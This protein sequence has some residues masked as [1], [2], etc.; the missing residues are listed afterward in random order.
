[1]TSSVVELQGISKKY[2]RRDALRDVTLSLE[3]G[4][5]ALLGRNGAGKTTM[6]RILAGDTAADSGEVVRAGTRIDGGSAQRRR[7]HLAQTGWLPQA[8]SAPAWMQVLAFVEYAAWLKGLDVA[9]ARSAAVE[10][11]DRVN[12]HGARARRV[13]ELSGGQLRRLGIAQAMAHEPGLLVLD[14]PTVGLD[15]EQRQQFHEI[16]TSLASDRC[17]LL[18]THLVEDVAALGSRVVVLDRGA[19]AF[20]GT[21]QELEGRG[22]GDDRNDR[23]R[24]AFLAVAGSAEE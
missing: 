8:F 7:A 12:L 1:M 21:L 4:V 16:V 9:R 13:G 10:A 20:D 15:P 23:I 11:L 5:T 2:R 6:C 22:H 19:I 24:S 14:E 18:S 3:P 17:V